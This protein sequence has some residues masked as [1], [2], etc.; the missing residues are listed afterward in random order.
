MEKMIQLIILYAS[1]QLFL[2]E[3]TSK[4]SFWE[5]VALNSPKSTISKE[6]GIKIAST[7]CGEPLIL[8][9]NEWWSYAVELGYQVKQFHI[10]RNGL[11]QKQQ[12]PTP[13]EIILGSWN[14]SACADYP[15]P[16]LF[17][18]IRPELYVD[19]RLVRL[20]FPYAEVGNGFLKNWN[21]FIQSKKYKIV[22]KASNNLFL[23]D[24]K[25]A[26]ENLSSVKYKIVPGAKNADL[27]KFTTIIGKYIFCPNCGFINYFKEGKTTVFATNHG[28]ELRKIKKIWDDTFIEIDFPLI[29]TE[30]EETRISQPYA[31][32][33]TLLFEKISG[34]L[35]P[36]S[37]FLHGEETEFWKIQENDYIAVIPKS[38]YNDDIL[39]ILRE[40]FFK[41]VDLHQ[42]SKVSNILSHNILVLQKPFS[43]VEISAN[44]TYNFYVFDSRISNSTVFFNN[45]FWNPHCPSQIRAYSDTKY[46]YFALP[47]FNL[48]S[49]GQG[50]ISF[51]IGH[52][53]PIAFPSVTLNLY[54]K[55]DPLFQI[56]I[57]VEDGHMSIIH[58]LADEDLA[59]YDEQIY[60]YLQNITHIWIGIYNDFIYLGTGTK[61][62]SGLKIR[63]SHPNAKLIT[64]FTMVILGQANI[65][66]LVV[67]DTVPYVKSVFNFLE[68]IP[69]PKSFITY[70]EHLADGDSDDCNR[71][72]KI[73]YVCGPRYGLSEV[74][75]ISDCNYRV[76][77][78][79]PY[80]CPQN[81]TLIPDDY[82]TG[83]SLK[84][85]VIKAFQIKN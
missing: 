20:I 37:Y 4:T 28:S 69:Q 12:D 54:S 60:S 50:L 45:S 24:S 71:K 42:I 44:E 32:D 2:S 79:T 58:S 43:P 84:K 29:G 5:Q 57:G 34:K 26:N 77:L 83:V 11:F 66:D 9:T 10:D 35:I 62:G 74:D 55:T 41:M 7:L 25:P 18:K 85:Y 13:K 73:E 23:L 46:Q 48:I 70:T 67:I 16:G 49:T 33:T 39:F 51:A 76:V 21:I 3:E 19:G 72:T 6:T 63:Y 22:L 8:D 53:F 68:S 64:H 56:I 75:E 1:F 17:N 65:S 40:D 14:S 78:T 80:I 30:I 81:Y 59:V 31:S 52:T 61:L 27:V 36:S 82:S 15:F 38:I 47:C